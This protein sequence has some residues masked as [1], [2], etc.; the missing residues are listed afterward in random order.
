MDFETQRPRNPRLSPRNVGREGN[1]VEE[2]SVRVRVR[3]RIKNRI[4][5]RI[6]I[7]VIYHK[8]YVT[9]RK[10]EKMSK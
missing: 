1:M 2:H 7:R 6:I 5:N 3:V 8:D 9:G 10:K 4:K